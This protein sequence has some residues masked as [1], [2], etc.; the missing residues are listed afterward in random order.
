MIGLDTCVLIDIFKNNRSLVSLL[1]SINET[2]YVNQLVYLEIVMGLD[3]S[4]E[5]H[6]S[7]EAFY[8]RLFSSFPNLELSPE[9]SKLA[10]KILWELKVD[11]SPI[12]AIDCAIAGIYLSNGV[13]TIVTKNKKH[14]EKIKGLKVLSY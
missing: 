10:R 3:P 8:D 7:E 6:Q 12:G 2:I 5:K 4:N 1:S 9:A 13:D 11:G 14:F